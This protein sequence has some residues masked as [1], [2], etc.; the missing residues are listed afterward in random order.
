M[1]GVFIFSMLLHLLYSLY[2]MPTSFS[3]CPCQP[4]IPHYPC[5]LYFLYHPDCYFKIS[6]NSFSNSSK[7]AEVPA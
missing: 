2:A 6:H 3:T 5:D 7:V 1:A 4:L